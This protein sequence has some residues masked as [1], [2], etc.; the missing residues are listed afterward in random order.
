MRK[1]L[2]ILTVALAIPTMSF[3]E[4]Q[5]PKEICKTMYDTIGVFLAIADKAWKSQDEEKALLYSTAAANYAT[6]YELT[7]KR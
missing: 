3:A 6:V 7:C 1:L 2:A 4:E 5:Y